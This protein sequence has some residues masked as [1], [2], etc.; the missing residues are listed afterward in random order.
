MIKIVAVN[1]LIDNKRDEFIQITKK[2]IEESRKEN[3]CISYALFQDVNQP[4]ILTFIEE[5][6]SKEAIAQHNLTNHFTEI[7]PLLGVLCT[8]PCQVSLYEEI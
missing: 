8:V 4:N 2:L 7:C 6:E 1:H 5:W 3:G